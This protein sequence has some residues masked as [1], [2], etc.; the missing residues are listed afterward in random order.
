MDNSYN[1][2][3]QDN[4]TILDNWDTD[5]EN[6]YQATDISAQVSDMDSIDTSEDNKVQLVRVCLEYTSIRVWL[7]YITIRIQLKY[8]SIEA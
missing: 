7:E 3:L 6:P 8:T 2:P 1:T 5:I 4:T